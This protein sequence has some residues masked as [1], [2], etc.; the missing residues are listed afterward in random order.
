MT[1]ANNNCDHDNLQNDQLC[2]RNKVALRPDKTA[3]PIN[4]FLD[5]DLLKNVSRLF[6][7]AV[8]N[9]IIK[10]PNCLIVLKRSFIANGFNG[11]GFESLLR[12][13]YIVKYFRLFSFP[14][15]PFNQQQIQ[16]LGKG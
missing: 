11:N 4:L 14:L 6:Y 7:F 1:E 3:S 10:N 5:I 15:T 12:T 13:S 9:T 2:S 8:S 16:A